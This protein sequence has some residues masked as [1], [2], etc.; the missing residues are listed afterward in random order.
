MKNENMLP[1][2]EELHLALKH[3]DQIS[4]VGFLDKHNISRSVRYKL[5]EKG[6]IESNGLRASE[7]RYKWIADEPNEAM[8][9]L[10]NKRKN[11][12]NKRKP[13]SKGIAVKKTVSKSTSNRVK[14]H[15]FWGAIKIEL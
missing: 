10:I 4:V 5:K 11:R 13:I 9:R 14:V 3:T 1:M 6:I 2:L 15:L 7:C 12:V 8:V